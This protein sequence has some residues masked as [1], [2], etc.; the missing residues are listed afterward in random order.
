MSYT[1]LNFGKTSSKMILDGPYRYSNNYLLFNDYKSERLAQKEVKKIVSFIFNRQGINPAWVLDDK[2]W[3][4]QV[5]YEGLISRRHNNPY[6]CGCQHCYEEDTAEL[7]AAHAGFPK[8]RFTKEQVDP[9]FVALCTIMTTCKNHAMMVALYTVLYR[10]IHGPGRILL[11]S[12][13]FR[14]TLHNLFYMDGLLEGLDELS[15][16]EDKYEDAKYHLEML[17]NI[18]EDEDGH[19][20]FHD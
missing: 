6:V 12:K 2:L 10:F 13:H 20:I 18:A 15:E 7:K 9:I 1:C 11:K 5:E 19:N 16:S 3:K 4:S 17:V 8:N 14:T